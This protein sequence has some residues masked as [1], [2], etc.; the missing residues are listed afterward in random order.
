[1][2]LQA[3]P[4]LVIETKSPLVRVNP[5]TYCQISAEQKVPVQGNVEYKE[6][7]SRQGNIPTENGHMLCRTPASE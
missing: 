2:R 7:G 6:R 1:M 3:N 5:S 4:H